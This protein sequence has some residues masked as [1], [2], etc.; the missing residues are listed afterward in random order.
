[1][2]VLNSQQ[3]LNSINT[4]QQKMKVT[5]KTL[6]NQSKIFDLDEDQSV[7]ELKWKINN[8]NAI[9]V[10]SQRLVYNGISLQDLRMLSYY[11]ILES[12]PIIVIQNLIGD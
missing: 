5:V 2:R 10:E 7:L 3:L 4:L 12:F 6:T 1:M 11:N 9:P 8:W